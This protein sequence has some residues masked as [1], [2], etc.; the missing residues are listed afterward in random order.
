MNVLV[1][2]SRI[3]GVELAGEI[4]RTYLRAAYSGEERNRRRVAKIEALEQKFK[5]LIEDKK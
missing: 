4:A 5:S 1:L 2:G 3:I